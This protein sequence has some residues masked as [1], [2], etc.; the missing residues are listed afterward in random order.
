VTST[1]S[2]SMHSGREGVDPEVWRVCPLVRRY[3]GAYR[4]ARSPMAVPQG[5]PGSAA[6]A[7]FDLETHPSARRGQH[8]LASPVSTD[9]LA[10]DNHRRGHTTTMEAVVLEI[11]RTFVPSRLSATYLAAAYAQVV[12]DRRRRTGVSHAAE[13]PKSD[14]SWRRAV[15]EGGGIRDV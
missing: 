13:A 10:T 6:D 8:W 1:L 3:H 4:P 14:T 2:G 5:M 7:S 15:G 11:R 9:A 12:P